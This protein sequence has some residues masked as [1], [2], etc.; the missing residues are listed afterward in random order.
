M[1]DSSE[2]KRRLYH[3]YVT[4]WNA[5]AQ[6]VEASSEDEALDIA[7]ADYDETLDA[8]WKLNDGGLTGFDVLDCEEIDEIGGAQ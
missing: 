7:R 4:T 5:H 6:W 3:V 8:N 1:T 2:N